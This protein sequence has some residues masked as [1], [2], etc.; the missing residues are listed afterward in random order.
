MHEQL[1]DAAE[2]LRNAVKPFARPY[3]VRLS[4]ESSC[5]R[6]ALCRL[7]AV[8]FVPQGDKQEAG[9][10]QRNYIVLQIVVVIMSF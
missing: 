5:C 10:H 2:A 6:S 1:H 8:L 9:P 3:K 7:P 4:G